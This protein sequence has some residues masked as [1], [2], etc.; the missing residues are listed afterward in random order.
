MTCATPPFTAK[1]KQRLL[2]SVFPLSYDGAKWRFTLN[3]PI[4]VRSLRSGDVHRHADGSVTVFEPRLQ[5]W[6]IRP[7]RPQDYYRRIRAPSAVEA[8]QASSSTIDESI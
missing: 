4:G 2:W 8:D 1:A 6:V 5:A 7:P 3:P